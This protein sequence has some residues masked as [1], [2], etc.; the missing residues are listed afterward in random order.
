MPIRPPEPVAPYPLGK[1]HPPNAPKRPWAVLFQHASV[2]LAA[3][4][5]H[6]SKLLALFGI[7]YW[8][9]ELPRPSSTMLQIVGQNYSKYLLNDNKYSIIQLYVICTSA[10]QKA[11][12]IH[13]RQSKAWPDSSAAWHLVD[14][15]LSHRYLH[16]ALQKYP[17]KRQA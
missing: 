10:P 16:R 14:L 5:M 7:V 15:V 4:S 2:S 3:C 17:K 13:M 9:V 1:R 12:I 6:V 8:L 11:H